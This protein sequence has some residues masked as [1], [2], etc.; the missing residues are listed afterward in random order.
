MKK[1]TFE[2]TIEGKWYRCTPKVNPKT[3]LF[4]IRGN[5][6]Y[7]YK[8]AAVCS[9]NNLENYYVKPD[10]VFSEIWNHEKFCI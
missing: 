7:D 2:E 10:W 4:I 6:P 1:L 8:N 5:N 9:S 3:E